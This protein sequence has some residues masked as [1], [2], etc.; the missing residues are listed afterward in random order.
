MHHSIHTSEIL[1]ALLGV[2]IEQQT[3]VAKSL[4]MGTRFIEKPSLYN[5]Q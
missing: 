4:A 1:I 2:A 3:P 5:K